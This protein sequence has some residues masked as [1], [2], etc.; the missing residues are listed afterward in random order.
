MFAILILDKTSRYFSELSLGAP[1]KTMEEATKFIA[2]SA[3]ESWK[4]VKLTPAICKRFRANPNAKFPEL[5]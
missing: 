5:L 3:P 2:E 1:F 4:A